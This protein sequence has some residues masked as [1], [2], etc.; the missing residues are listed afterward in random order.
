MKWTQE[1]LDHLCVLWHSTKREDILNA[2]P[3]RTWKSIERKANY[4]G[5]KRKRLL[6]HTDFQ[7]DIL[8]DWL[9]GEMLGDGHITKSGQFSYTTKHIDYCNFLCSKLQILCHTI[10]YPNSYNDRRTNKTYHRMII[11]TASVF[12]AARKEWYPIGKKIVPRTIPV[13]DAVLLHWILGDGFISKKNSFI[14]CTMGF[15]KTDVNAL[16]N[17]LQEYGLESSINSTNNIYIRRNDQ[18]K[19]TIRAFLNTADFPSCFAYKRDRLLG[20]CE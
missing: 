15:E 6:Y 17:K 2:F 4:L 10:S 14:L 5:L 9:I 7:I 12:K 19:T 1:N 16:V 11:K 3:G 13:N 20:W 8:D 18:N